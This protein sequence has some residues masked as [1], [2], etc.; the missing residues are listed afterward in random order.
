[1][2]L[3]FQNESDFCCCNSNKSSWKNN[4]HEVMYVHSHSIKNAFSSYTR[5]I[6]SAALDHG[7]KHPSCQKCWD[8]EDSGGH[9]QRQWANSNFGNEDP[10]PN[11]PRVLIIKPGN[12][13]N[14]ACRMCNPAT[15]SSWYSDGYQL[16]RKNLHS[17]SWYAT[18][19]SEQISTINFNQYTRT[20]ETIRNSFNSNNEELWGT[21]K[22]WLPGLLFI[23]V[24]GGEP[25]LSPAMFDLLEH[26]VN[27]GACKLIKLRIHTNASIF[28]QRYMEILSQ[29]K[30]VDFC[31]SID[32]MVPA[33]LEYIRHKCQYNSVVENTHRF[34][35]AINNCPHINLSISLTITPLNVFY[36]DKITKDLTDTF[37]LSVAQNLVHTPE[38]DIRHLP[39]PVKE[40]LKKTVKSV[41]VLQFLEKTIPGCDIEWPKFC[42][43][44]DRLDQLRKQSFAETFPEWWQILEPYWIKSE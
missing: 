41:A 43:V 44:T 35:Q 23:D 1:M 12:T 18:E 38:Y 28:N 27:I 15:S 40:L 13:C 11:Q 32:A 9:S 7:V 16:E 31:I 24:Y 42:Q 26:G 4:N 20:F 5:K 22:S 25:F 29:Y 8:V 19:N 37:D 21:L 30:Q 36:V 6:I 14:F 39:I 34:K 17:S 10:L 3:T 2:G 33:Q